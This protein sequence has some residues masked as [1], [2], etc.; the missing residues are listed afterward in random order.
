[1]EESGGNI[2]FISTNGSQQASFWFPAFVASRSFAVLHQIEIDLTLIA[3][4]P[5]ILLDFFH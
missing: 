4:W 3:N 2:S 1:M 5:I